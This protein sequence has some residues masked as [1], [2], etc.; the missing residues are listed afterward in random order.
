ML[1]WLAACAALVLLL[2]S[3]S[4]QA[5]TPPPGPSLGLNLTGVA[6]WS[7]EQPFLDHMKTARPWNAGTSEQWETWTNQQLAAEGYLSPE[8][9]PRELP[10]GA[11]SFQSV[12]LTDLP[13]DAGD[14]SG[15]Y[16]LR[17]EGDA[18]VSVSGLAHR[19]AANGRSLHFE[20]EPGDG[21]VLIQVSRV[22]PRDPLRSMTLV[23]ADQAALLENG[24]VFNPDFLAR[25]RDFRALR[26]MDWMGTN[27]S[28]QVSWENR[29]RVADASWMARGVPVEIMVQ[30]A[31]EVGADPWFTMPHMADDAY[32]AAFAGY[33][34]DHLDPRLEVHAEW[35]NEVWNFLFPQAR[36]AEEQATARWGVAPGGDAWMQFAGLR[37][38]EVADIWRDVFGPEAEDRLVRVVGVQIGWLGLEQPL[39]DAPLAVAEG[40]APPAESFDAYAVTG[41]FGYGIGNEEN[42]SQLRA[43]IDE[44][45]APEEVTELA[46]AEIQDLTERLWPYH[47]DVARQRGLELVAYEGGTHIVGHGPEIQGEPIT[48]FFMDYNY[49]PEMGELYRDLFEEWRELGGGL[50]IHYASVGRP[51]RY[52]SWG[53]LRHLGDDNPRWDALADANAQP[54]SW[55]SRDPASFA[56]GV[57]IMGDA[58]GEI[59]TGTVEEDDLLGFGGDDVLVSEGGADRLHGGEGRDRARLPGAAADWETALADGAV[60]LSRE[61]VTVRLT[62]IEE[63]EFSGTAEV[64]ALPAPR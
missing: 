46:R 57:Q 14:S 26:F 2:W 13:K 62:A 11:T 30:L 38:A 31:N 55:E 20:F 59:L 1:K 7:S 35:S 50:F 32:V 10:P 52:G 41:Y 63:V 43:W 27:G 16:V 21:L 34:R 60:L 47:A 53:A 12:V 17:W 61:A 25:I 8:G 51:S 4:G 28:L 44:G 24:A 6:D 33:V 29:P 54:A 56:Q 18:D 5:E 58:E 22:N 48:D 19:V 37:A 49:S 40:H 3:D 23:R 36:W 45:T 64:L 42:A 39:L 9:W 15:S